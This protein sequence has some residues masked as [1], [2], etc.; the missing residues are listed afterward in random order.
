[1]A[2]NLDFL[3]ILAG[4]DVN[5]STQNIQKQLQQI[6]KNLKGVKVPL[7]VDTKTI[8]KAMKQMPKDMA[9]DDN[10]AEG[11]A[12]LLN[13]IKEMYKGQAYEVSKVV[14][15]LHKQTVRAE[16]LINRLDGTVS[17]ETVAISGKYDKETKGVDWSQPSFMNFGTDE[18]IKASKATQDLTK[19]LNLQGKEINKLLQTEK[20]RQL[21]SEE[22]ALLD[23]RQVTATDKLTSHMAM[24]N[25]M[26]QQ[27][28]ISEQKYLEL[29]NQTVAARAQLISQIGSVDAQQ[30]E[31]DKIEEANRAYQEYKHTIDQIKIY[32]NMERKGTL[33]DP[34]DITRYKELQNAANA[35]YN[36]VISGEIDYVDKAQR[37]TE[38]YYAQKMKY[39]Q[40]DEYQ[41]QI[42]E[43]R[44]LRDLKN[45][46]IAVDEKRQKFKL[47]SSSL[48]FTSEGGVGQDPVVTD[49][50]N[51]RE[52]LKADFTKQFESIKANNPFPDIVVSIEAM[53]NE[54]EEGIA[55]NK[56][57]LGILQ[58]QREA[59]IK[60]KYF[61]GAPVMTTEL[62]QDKPS[63]TAKQ[64][65]DF[66]G[67]N[68]KELFADTNAMEKLTYALGGHH[69]MLKKNITTTQEMGQTLHH[70]T[71]TVDTDQKHV[72]DLTYTFREF[73][74]VNG[75]TQREI[76][77]TNEALRANANRM[78]GVWEMLKLTFKRMATWALMGQLVYGAIRKIGEG[79]RWL[80]D[81]NKELVQSAIV[82]GVHL[83]ST[84]KQLAQYIALGQQMGI[85]A[86]EIAKV[87]TE[88]QRQGLSL[89][90]SKVR[91]Q[92]ILKLS[93]TGMTTVAQAMQTVTT[94]VN[95]L[96]VAHD[97]AA[98][99]I[100][101]ASMISASDVEGI[102]E[103]LS[104]TASSAFAAGLSIEQTTGI[105]AGLIQVTQEGSSQIGNSLK[106]IL[107]RFN[108]VN[109]ETGEYNQELN[110]IHTALKTIGVEYLTADGQIRNTY[111]VLKDTAA[112]WDT[113]TKNQQAYIATVGAGVRMQS[114]FYAIMQ[115]FG[116]IDNFVNTLYDSE[117]TLADSFETQLTGYEAKLNKARASLEGIWANIMPPDLME[118]IISG[119]SDFTSAI[120]T[121]LTL[122]NKIPG[123]VS[124]VFNMIVGTGLTIMSAL[125]GKLGKTFTELSQ[126][127]LTFNEAL[128]QTLN[129]SLRIKKANTGFFATFKTNFTT[130]KADL[131]KSQNTIGL[132]SVQARALANNFI[133]VKAATQ[134][135]AL[136]LSAVSIQM[137]KILLG[138]A[139]FSKTLL[140]M[141]ALQA[142]VGLA[143]EF[144]TGEKALQAMNERLDE[145]VT[146]LEA[147]RAGALESANTFA[148][149]EKLSNKKGA[150]TSDEQQQFYDVSNKIAELA[151][152]LVSEYDEMG[153]AILTSNISLDSFNEAL[154]EQQKLF[155]MQ[156]R[157]N[158]SEQYKKLSKELGETT[159][160]LEASKQ[161]IE[162]LLKGNS[163][164]ARIAEK[165][166]L[167]GA[168]TGGALI[169]D[170]AFSTV[171]PDATP[172]QRD[173]LQQR[174][175]SMQAAN[176]K[177]IR[178][179]QLQ[180]WR[181]SQPVISSI[182]EDAGLAAE[183][184]KA[185]QIATRGIDVSSLKTLRQYEGAVTNTAI[186]IKENEQAFV[187]IFGKYDTL[188][189]KMADGELSTQDFNIEVEKIRAELEKLLST[190]DIPV[191]SS[192]IVKALEAI[193]DQKEGLATLIDRLTILKGR[194]GVYDDF[195]SQVADMHE[196]FRETGDINFQS[197]ME[198]VDA[199]DGMLTMEQLLLTTQEEKLGILDSTVAKMYEAVKAEKELQLAQAKT[200][201]DEKQKAYDLNPNA[202]THAELLAAKK[203]I[204]Y[205]QTELSTAM[206]GLLNSFDIQGQAGSQFDYITEKLQDFNKYL[207][208]YN[209]NKSLSG[210][211]MQEIITK[212]PELIGLLGDEQSMR[213]E[214]ADLIAQEDA[215][216]R[217]ALARKL[218]ATETFYKNNRQIYINIFK[219]L[220]DQYGLDV[221]NFRTTQQA[222]LEISAE[223]QKRIAKLNASINVG[224]TTES[225][226]QNIADLK[227]QNAEL[228]DSALSK[229]FN[230]G[231]IKKNAEAINELQQYADTLAAADKVAENVVAKIDLTPINTSIDTKKDKKSSG[232]KQFVEIL[233]ILPRYAAKLDDLADSY[234]KATSAHEKLFKRINADKYFATNHTAEYFTAQVAS[235]QELY[236]L[237]GKA[238]AQQTE[239]KKIADQAA[240]AYK[241]QTGLQADASNA[242]ASYLNW[243]QTKETA[244]HNLT[245]KQK[246]IENDTTKNA[247]SERIK[248]IQHEIALADYHRNAWEKATTQLDGL[249]DKWWELFSSMQSTMEELTN[250]TIEKI[251]KF[252]EAMVE[253]VQASRGE[254]GRYNRVDDIHQLDLLMLD[255][256]KLQKQFVSTSGSF[257]TSN[258]SNGINKVDIDTRALL[259][260]INALND[261]RKR[262]MDDKTLSEVDKQEMLNELIEK[263][264]KLEKELDKEKQHILEKLNAME[265]EHRAIENAMQNRIELKEDELKALQK[266]K[267]LE[268]KI[269]QE[270]QKQLDLLRAMDDTRFSY[271]TGLG[272]EIFTYDRSKLKDLES[273]IDSD[274]N[275]TQE[276]LLQE[277]IDK[278]NEQLNEYKE[279]NRIAEETLRILLGI[280][281]NLFST[282]SS[283][284]DALISSLEQVFE[285]MTEKLT[286]NIGTIFDKWYEAQGKKDTKTAKDILN[287]YNSMDSL[288][289]ALFKQS[290]PKLDSFDTGGYTG[291]WNG[292]DGKLAMVHQKELV[293]NET[294]TSNILAAINAL[295]NFNFAEMGFNKPTSAI[296]SAITTIK[297]GVSIYLQN[298]RFVTEN[299]NTFGKDMQALASNTL[300]RMG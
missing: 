185:L 281:D 9:L 61:S 118:T 256:R 43:L 125:R 102:G 52:A 159:S 216:Q 163:I 86:L 74:D 50:R 189:Q 290:L 211:N 142:V 200:V 126:G 8:Q 83:S 11:K 199:S 263:Q 117:G 12:L 95:A 33:V 181:Q 225:V 148:E 129:M 66:K 284:I 235:M 149:Y 128:G 224:T 108:A 109:E 135:T 47:S 157:A 18:A 213:A 230:S 192:A 113:L 288:M 49:L 131:L 116:T 287:V 273:N 241:K 191:D 57:L 106:T 98:D 260:T 1:M 172:M 58:A 3:S 73:K 63:L 141:V 227:K 59:K 255:L 154:K 198:T 194:L 239:I 22:Q 144:F 155:N 151:P 161:A 277:E 226:Q 147:I 298:P 158:F 67:L 121:F 215:L 139:A 232:S 296:G 272:E 145:T 208:D 184:M 168:S 97:K 14:S 247:Y 206:D 207:E 71:I 274:G 24:L 30:K 107:A 130:I 20:K 178:D 91:M 270:Q 293:L 204:A 44:K 60:D 64:L 5:D 280:N 62:G 214:L 271:I 236:A 68:T 46:I 101:K 87:T 170:K 54:M 120:N 222:K 72:R 218:E 291:N 127:A 275:D 37:T 261:E 114:R 283:D 286:N 169:Q 104:K 69:A 196:A 210:G 259:N 27:G 146:K 45:E 264:I 53:N 70:F 112:I 140:I 219:N 160:E 252:K 195:A 249:N 110:K 78:L 17:K 299:A 246:F 209:E 203:D 111:D 15:E 77:K 32:E 56:Q 136:S 4:L 179:K 42:K 234:E 138:L 182:G 19:E 245:Q 39:K 197:L 51:K 93:A 2:Q 100:L 262:I 228:S 253:A 89:E 96:G 103:A 75:Q 243:K 48:G 79:F 220:A 244:I 279:A 10:M 31:I 229:I 26:K 35:Y 300:S 282:L 80:L 13:N 171:N 55:K 133:N 28:L 134:A 29:T 173:M 183:G 156:Y 40:S 251:G 76:Y 82:Q 205:I 16:V 167:S 278:M 123:N 174:L 188:K 34:K 92:T 221:E 187:S 292:S 165:L 137:Q 294:D 94:A 212:Y 152:T 150:F 231:K 153:N 237:Q 122:I 115:N 119:I 124:P 23:Y 143:H 186:A 180:M 41:A 36:R 295:K 177:K 85:P 269:R 223:V 233:R 162:S 266:Q 90:E 25:N 65:E 289:K 265:L 38:M 276:T 164:N 258:L 268:E 240:I 190:L 132:A 297:E 99:I 238:L 84:N 267:Q 6:S 105:M 257:N 250:T 285:Q 21:T 242:E 248:A 193:V 254:F 175:K 7:E 217:K 201:R 176:D 166:G 202:D 81:I 88:L